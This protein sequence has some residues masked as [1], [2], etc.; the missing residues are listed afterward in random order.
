MEDKEIKG[1]LR[2]LIRF[3]LY[4]ALVIST[5]ILGGCTATAYKTQELQKIL[6]MSM[7]QPGENM[8]LSTESTSKNYS[9]L[10]YKQTMLILEEA[11]V[12]PDRVFPGDVINQRIRY[13][14]CPYTPSGT[15]Q[16]KIIRTILFKGE[17][18]FQDVTNY[19]YKPGT[20]KVDVFIDIPYNARAGVYAVDVDLTSSTQETIRGSDTFIVKSR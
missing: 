8:V 18:V 19:E 14:L 11:D 6:I 5:L 7:R 17:T 3:F 16:G 12:I 20:W 15:I 13:A 10:P 1:E 9:C 4:I 2:E